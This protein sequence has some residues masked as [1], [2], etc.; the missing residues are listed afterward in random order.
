MNVF[1]GEWMNEWSADGMHVIVLH[2]LRATQ[3]ENWTVLSCYE[4]YIYYD[5][6]Y[7]K[8]VRERPERERQ[9]REDRN[10]ECPLEDCFWL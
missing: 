10:K 9:E 6:Y 8:S 1:A 2:K 3:V 7:D 5:I 4:A